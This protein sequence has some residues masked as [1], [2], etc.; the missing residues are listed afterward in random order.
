MR[1]ASLPDVTVCMHT[2]PVSIHATTPCARRWPTAGSCSKAPVLSVALV[3]ESPLYSCNVRRCSLHLMWLSDTI[4][5]GVTTP[6]NVLGR[7]RSCQAS[8]KG[9]RGGTG[10]VR[11]A[12]PGASSILLRTRLAWVCTVQLCGERGTGAVGC[13][14]WQQQED[15]DVGL[16]LIGLWICLGVPLL[17]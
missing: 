15:I 10:G 3:S 17:F 8:S 16:L 7:V 11:G 4:S 13:R 12:G 5:P 6:S 14:R 1:G 2:V 9:S